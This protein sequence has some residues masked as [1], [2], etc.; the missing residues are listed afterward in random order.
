MGCAY[1]QVFGFYFSR[2]FSMSSQQYLL[3][4]AENREERGIFDSSTLQTELESDPSGLDS[5]EVCCKFLSFPLGVV[6]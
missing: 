1:L 2:E 4:S 5:S 3:S 6:F